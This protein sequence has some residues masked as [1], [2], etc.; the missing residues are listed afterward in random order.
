[1]P[2]NC[3]T[4]MKVTMILPVQGDLPVTDF[5][6]KLEVKMVGEDVEDDT[7]VEPLHDGRVKAKAKSTV[8]N[9]A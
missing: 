2:A 4:K 3:Q 1:M 5:P 9:P 8:K 7:L 6:E